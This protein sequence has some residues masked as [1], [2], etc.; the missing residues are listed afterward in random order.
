[1]MRQWWSRYINRIRRILRPWIE[2]VSSVVAGG[3]LFGLSRIAAAVSYGSSPIEGRLIGNQ[4]AVNAIIAVLLGVG[5]LLS[6]SRRAWEQ[7]TKGEF[8]KVKQLA[9]VVDFS[10]RAHYRDLKEFNDLY[11]AIVDPHYE[12]VRSGVLL[13]ATNRL[14][15]MALS[16]E[17]GPLRTNVYVGLERAELERPANIGLRVRALATLFP[18]D[19]DPTASIEERE[20]VAVNVSFVRKGGDFERTFL[21]S[22]EVYEME[23]D[24]EILRIHSGQNP[25]LPGRIAIREKV[26]ERQPGL[27][28]S[29]GAG[30]LL[31]GTEVGFID[32]TDSPTGERGHMVTNQRLLETY[33]E[34][35]DELSVHTIHMTGDMT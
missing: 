11:Q 8:R 6:L 2:L 23:K 21:L 29:L 1:M 18:G 19:L 28:E 16:G 3:I 10:R 26:A 13:D 32:A 15:P 24:V 5:A 34:L 9:K 4:H 30:F 14:R 20:F 35:Y 22:Q 17:S 31:F 25:L 27:L 7:H 33:Q 12:A